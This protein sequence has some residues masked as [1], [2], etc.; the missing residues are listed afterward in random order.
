MNHQQLSPGVVLDD[1]YTIDETLGSGGFGITYSAINERIGLKVCIKEFFNAD[2]MWRADDGMSIYVDEANEKTAQDEM[3]RFL[4][5]ARII[6]DFSNTAGIVHMLDY[7]EANGT[8]YIVMDL[9]EGENLK[10]KIRREGAMEPE[11]LVRSMFPLM[12]TLG[13]LHS[14]GVIH[15]DISPENIMV[16]PEGDFKLID[17]GAAKRIDSKTRTMAVVYKEGYAPPE[18]Y[19]STGERGPW[20]DIYGLCATMYYC[21]TNRAPEN[22]LY[23]ILND[24]LKTPK[25]LGVTLLPGLEKTIMKGLRLETDKRWQTVQ[26]LIDALKKEYPDPLPDDGGKRR[27]KKIAIISVIAAA[28]VC[29]AG[30][31]LMYYQRHKVEIRF[32]SIETTSFTLTPDEDMSMKDYQ[33]SSQVIKG[34]VEAWAGKD[35]YLWKEDSRDDGKIKVTVP[36][37]IFYDKSP[38]YVVTG[39]LSRPMSLTAEIDGKKIPISR[40]DITQSAV[41]KMTLPKEVLKEA[42][43]ENDDYVVIKCSLSDD[44]AKKLKDYLKKK[45]LVFRLN[46]DLEED[47]ATHYYESAVTCGDES[48]FYVICTDP[49]EE[50]GRVLAYDL[51]HDSYASSGYAVHYEPIIEWF[52]PDASNALAGKYQCDVDEIGEESILLE[53]GTDG[54]TDKLTDDK[55]IYAQTV[56][57]L[58]TRLDSIGKPY[59]VGL[60]R[61]SKNVIIKM[62]RDDLWGAQL[63]L[64]SKKSEWRI[65]DQKHKSYRVS[66]WQNSKLSIKEN[67]GKPELVFVPSSE[68]YVISGI[69]NYLARAKASG[70]TEIEIAVSDNQNVLARIGIEEAIAMFAEENAFTIRD[71]ALEDYTGTKDEFNCFANFLIA[72]QNTQINTAVS[73]RQAVLPDGDDMLPAFGTARGIP[74]AYGLSP[75]EE[76]HHKYEWKYFDLADRIKDEEKASVS[77]NPDASGEM[78]FVRYYQLDDDVFRNDVLQKTKEIIQKYHLS[79][80]S[81]TWME[82]MFSTADKD[83]SPDEADLKFEMLL[84]PSD[85]REGLVIDIVGLSGKKATNELK[86]Q[87]NEQLAADPFFVQLNPDNKGIRIDQEAENP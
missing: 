47:Y 76:M 77:Y 56:A 43:N 48:S 80:T 7:F 50:Y 73:L 32:R 11:K 87:L 67:N 44:A 62:N 46:Y 3:N 71:F 54:R 61:S 70:V 18:Q 19:Q 85:D 16:T 28:L 58:E 4:K 52:R 34:R 5:E 38:D 30:F 83:T 81:L 63:Q 75:L 21:L 45:N 13:K 36:T 12:Q 23:R 40:S 59:A 1:R 39:Y 31:A 8:A 15:R 66:S 64:L 9:I 74:F 79:D 17:F 29:C 86:Q 68:A 78:M 37:K 27:R 2:Y 14:A 65:C 26:E 35:Q 24:E 42:G 57:V 20:I 51:G 6:S 41:E 82:F 69:T 60:D 84:L 33:E 55:G 10:E 49:E 53:I 25:E 22:A 72:I